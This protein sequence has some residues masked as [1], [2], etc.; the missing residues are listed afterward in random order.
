M[1]ITVSEPEYIR[2]GSPPDFA[3]RAICNHNLESLSKDDSAD[4]MLC[5]SPTISFQ[6]LKSYVSVK[7]EEWM[8]VYVYNIDCTNG[9]VCRLISL[10][11]YV[12]IIYNS[13]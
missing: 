5:G 4:E 12:S 3:L 13:Q 9:R 1:D 6:L 8:W 2:Y 7:R 10:G 11:I